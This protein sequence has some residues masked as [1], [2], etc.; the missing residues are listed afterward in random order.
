VVGAERRNAAGDTQVAA[1]P[2]VTQASYQ[3]PVAVIAEMSIAGFTTGFS[4]FV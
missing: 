1:A 3:V 4:A 2:L